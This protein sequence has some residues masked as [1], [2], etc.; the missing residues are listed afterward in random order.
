[1]ELFEER[2]VLRK[3]AVGKYLAGREST[4]SPSTH[5]PLA[6]QCEELLALSR[7]VTASYSSNISEALENSF[8][9]LANGFVVKVDE[10]LDMV[11]LARCYHLAAMP[12]ELKELIL[13]VGSQTESYPAHLGHEFL[14]SY[15]RY[16]GAACSVSELAGLDRVTEKL[17]AHYI[18]LCERF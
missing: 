5:R 7:K 8:G 15:R 10:L 2:L 13:L 17:R 1:M 11:L 14:G 3:E 4:A 6:K 18:R 16:L 9:L 12:R